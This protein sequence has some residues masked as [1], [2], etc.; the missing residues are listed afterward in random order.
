MR[1]VSAVL[2]AALLL[3][4]PACGD[5]DDGG[6]GAASDLSAEEQA[7]VDEAMQGFEA[8]EAEPLT[9]DDARCMVSSM[10]DR[11]G[12]ERME[13]VGLTAESFSS[14][15]ESMP[16]GLTEDEANG[17]V[18]GI[19]GCVD[20]HAMIL[21]GIIGAG[22]DLTEEEQD[23]I[24]EVF[25]EET[26]RTM[27][28]TMLTEGEDALQENEELMTSVFQAMSECPGLSG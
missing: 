15:S 7:F 24:A 11:L 25:D 5:D 2:L 19:D 16:S 9:E 3:V 28:V 23:C 26:V 21:E 10:V 4:A 12:V 22:D 17:V 1:K 13:E 8:E 18:D 20:L 14:S 6:D 27:F